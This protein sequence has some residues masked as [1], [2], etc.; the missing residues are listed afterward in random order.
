MGRVGRVRDW[1]YE[2]E[3]EGRSAKKE[4]E[5]TCRSWG[6]LGKVIAPELFSGGSDLMF[7]TQTLMLRVLRPYAEALETTH[8]LGGDKAVRDLAASLLEPM[9]EVPADHPEIQFAWIVKPIATGT[10]VHKNAAGKEKCYGEQGGGDCAPALRACAHHRSGRS[11][12]S[13]WT[14]AGTTRRRP[15][16]WSLSPSGRTTTGKASPKGGYEGT[17]KMSVKSR[18]QLSV[19]DF[20]AEVRAGRRRLRAAR[21]REFREAGWPVEEV[22]RVWAGP[23]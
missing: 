5:H 16:R 19:G 21:A 6:V 23:L 9:A 14:R 22:V 12:A 3:V 11:A 1:R 7:R 18:K 17:S 20:I 10:R 13:T 8:K 2:A 4:F 15:T